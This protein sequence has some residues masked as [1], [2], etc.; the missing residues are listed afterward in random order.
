V[1][2]LYVLNGSMVFLDVILTFRNRSLDAQAGSP[3][4]LDS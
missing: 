2:V 1:L 3:A 4:P